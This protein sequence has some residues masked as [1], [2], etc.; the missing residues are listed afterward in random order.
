MTESQQSETRAV[1][2]RIAAARRRAGLTQ[3]AFAERLGWPR[4][5]L[6]HF[7]HGRRALTVDRLK[8]VA[9]ALGLPPAALLVDDPLLSQLI[10]RL[11]DEPELRAQVEFFVRTLDTEL[12]EEPS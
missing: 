11:V 2:R 10:A 4:D 8:A 3:A 1:G 5:T 6:I 9:A 12:P 7:E